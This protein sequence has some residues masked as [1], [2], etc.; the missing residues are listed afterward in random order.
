MITLDDSRLAVSGPLTLRTHRSL[1]EASLAHDFEKINE[2]D[3]SQV[4]EVDSSALSLV[5]AWVRAAGGHPVAL[6]NPPESLLALA[7]LY[8]VVELLGGQLIH[9]EGIPVR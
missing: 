4:T 9:K 3:L 1:R 8:G 7:D 2:I 5:F 6:L